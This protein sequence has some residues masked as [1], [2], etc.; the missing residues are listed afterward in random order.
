[1]DPEGVREVFFAECGAA[2]DYGI[3]RALRSLPFMLRFKESFFFGVHLPL[4]TPLPKRLDTMMA[5]RTG[6]HA[7]DAS[8]VSI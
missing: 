7:F 8:G 1:M 3:R 5:Q 4:T 2:A 6:L